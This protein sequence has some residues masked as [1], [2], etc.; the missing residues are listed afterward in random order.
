M[1]RLS[2]KWAPILSAQ[3]ET[4]MGYQVASVS[5]KDGR[6]FND[7]LIAG[8][9]VTRIGDQTDIPFGDADI[10][11]IVVTHGVNARL[12][13][14]Y[15]DVEESSAGV[16]RVTG[17]SVEILGRTGLRYREGERSMFVDSE[18][19]A[20]PAGIV[21]Y[22]STVN[23]WESPHDAEELPPD[24]RSRILASIVAILRAQGIDVDLL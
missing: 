2:D 4:G 21:V 13:D 16:R 11:G 9:I 3:P 22:Q 6:Q 14:C 12:R 24:A 5:L 10:Q 8:G 7:V 23:R 17:R 18:V 1:L 20:P 19:L 15:F